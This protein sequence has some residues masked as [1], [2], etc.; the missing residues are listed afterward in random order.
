[1]MGPGMTCLKGMCAQAL[2]DGAVAS[3]KG[4]ILSLVGEVSW[5]SGP[6]LKGFTE[7]PERLLCGKGKTPRSPVGRHCIL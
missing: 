2:F 1:M 7:G 4:L 6:V 5:G 3:L